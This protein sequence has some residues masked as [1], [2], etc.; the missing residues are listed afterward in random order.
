MK[1]IDM[2][3]QLTGIV[4]VTSL[5]IHSASADEPAKD[6]ILLTL[7]KIEWALDV[8]WPGLVIKAQEITPDGNNCRFL[9]EDLRRGF[10]ISGYLEKHPELGTPKQCRDFYWAKAQQ[11][12]FKKDDISLSDLGEMAIVEY[13]VK[14]YEGVEINQKHVNAYLTRD[15]FWIDIHLSKVDFKKR[16]QRLFDSVLRKIKIIEKKQD[17]K[18]K[19][20]YRIAGHG[21]FKLEFPGTWLNQM[22][23][24][25]D[26]LPVQITLTP[27]SPKRSKVLITA[28]WDN[29]KNDSPSTPLDI[30]KMV[31]EGGQEAL[32][33]AVEDTLAIK[34]L[35]GRGGIG[36]CY[37]LTDKAPKPDEYKYLTQ[38]IYKLKTLLMSFTILTNEENSEVAE[39]A[40]DMIAGSSQASDPKKQ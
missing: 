2:L 21:I 28:F 15:N 33:Q 9:A 29:R 5:M 22:H 32:P 30:R 10:A 12:P 31:E 34:K 7:P 26:D 16:D 25:S 24:E 1:G 36:Y 14:E 11:S 27:P 20:N 6:S 4:F 18:I 19:A 38:G 23:Q 35:K 8:N 37:N 40:L 3:R 13:L 17:H 39:A